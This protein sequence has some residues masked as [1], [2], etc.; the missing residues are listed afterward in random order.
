[1][2]IHPTT[3]A[4]GLLANDIMKLTIFTRK[5]DCDDSRAGFFHDWLYKLAERVDFLSI[6]CLE[7]GKHN[8]PD[9]TEI[10]CL[11]KGRLW[12]FLRFLYKNPIRHTDAV[13]C[14][15]CPIYT[16]L[17]W[18]PAKIFRKKLLMWHTHGTKTRKLWLAS[19]MADKI[20]TATKD[21]FPYDNNKLVVTG[22]GIDTD[23]LTLSDTDEGYLLYIGRI[24]PIKCLEDILWTPHKKIVIGEATDSDYLVEV[25]RTAYNTTWLGG[26]P[27]NKLTKYIQDCSVL[28]SASR[29][30]SLDKVFLEAMACG[31]PVLTSN[32]TVANILGKYKEQLT[33][34]DRAELLLKLEKLLKKS[35]EERKEMGDYLRR[36][37][38][39][40]HTLDN[41]CDR[42][43][44]E[45]E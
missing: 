20:L 7:Q 9:N 17:S 36:I 30:N 8:L 37:V 28:I 13:F 24:S 3:K 25:Q 41:L 43:V 1:M 18:L 2:A 12:R 38:V 19:K 6:V 32:P 26:L 35:K 16:I 34:S 44:K 22:H 40:H 14:H 42:I 5:V 33:F 31:K 4:V 39:E 15:Q 23:A 21:S 27:H 11:G 45:T 10:I 29:T